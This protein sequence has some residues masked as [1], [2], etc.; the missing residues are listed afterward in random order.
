[1]ADGDED[2]GHVEIHGLA[3]FRALDPYPGDAAVVAEDLV[4]HMVPDEPHV[5]V[6]PRA[7][8]QFVHQD[9]L[10]AELVP[11]MYQGYRRGD[12]GEVNGFLDRG[13][14]AADDCHGLLP[15]EEA[16]AGGAGGHALA[17]ERFLRGQAKVLRR[18][19][20]RDDQRVA[21]VRRLVARQD[22]GVVG[23]GDGVD[24][25]EDD[26]GA[27]ALGVAEH[28]VHERRSLEALH[29]ARPVVDVGGGR[30]LPPLLYAGDQNGREI[31][32]CGV[33][34]GRIARRARPEYEHAAMLGIRHESKFPAWTG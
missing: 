24:V 12:V 11:A 16:V 31:R 2:A 22:E 9:G 1:V 6:R 30:E 33:D 26:L 29:I 5:T 23:E 25:V 34:G 27:E 3:G 17:F 13:V 21:G 18:R 8:H 7:A 15:V 32:P 19:T 20:R 4:Q 10:G 14:A 28:P